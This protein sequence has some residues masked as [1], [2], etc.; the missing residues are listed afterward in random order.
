VRFAFYTGGIIYISAVL[1]TIFSTKEYSPEEQEAFNVHETGNA[2]KEGEELVL[3]TQKYYT[4]GLAYLAIGLIATFIVYNYEWDKG[5]Y[6]LCLGIG[7]Y[8]L[9]QLITAQ[10]YVAGRRGGLVEIIY[11][12]GNMPTAMKQLAVVTVFTWFAMFSW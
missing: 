8:G 10:L 5:L 12:M 6:I 11:D 7:A 3:N 4:N 1:W 9:L 2:A